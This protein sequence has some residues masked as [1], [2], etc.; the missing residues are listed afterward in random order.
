MAYQNGIPTC[1]K[2][3]I[4]SHG[5]YLKRFS[6][7]MP[8][9]TLV[10]KS[11]TNLIDIRVCFRPKADITINHWKTT[12]GDQ[13]STEYAKLNNVLKVC[14]PKKKESEKINGLGITI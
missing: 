4:R 7:G 12:D 11:A 13:F 5:W 6:G 1:V 10:D 14:S 9:L 2:G 3:P 8:P